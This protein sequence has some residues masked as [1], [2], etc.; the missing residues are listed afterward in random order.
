MTNYNYAGSDIN[1]NDYYCEYSLKPYQYYK[2]WEHIDRIIL[3]VILTQGWSNLLK[4]KVK[5]HMKSGVNNILLI[6]IFCCKL[7]L[8]WMYEMLL[9][10]TLWESKRNQMKQIFYLQKID[11][12]IWNEWQYFRNENIWSCLVQY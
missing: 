12:I 3:Q 10:Q 4:T 5:Q 6:I 1:T 7:L 8:S 2:C 9:W 11:A